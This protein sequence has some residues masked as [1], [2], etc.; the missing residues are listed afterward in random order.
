VAP[1]SH[2][3]GLPLS[4]SPAF[5]TFPPAGSPRRGPGLSASASLWLVVA[6]GMTF[7]MFG[8]GAGSSAASSSELAT[9]QPATT[10]AAEAPGED[11]AV[12]ASI[13][14]VPD[15]AARTGVFATVGG[16][17]LHLPAHD[18]IVTGFHQASTPGS[19]AMTPASGHR[20]LPSRGRGY[21]ATS[22]V[23]IVMMD[24]QPVRSPVSGTVVAVEGYSLYGRYPDSRIRIRPHDDRD[25]RV[26]MLHLGGVEVEVGD[27]VEAGV[28]ELAKRAR[29]FPFRS[30]VDAETKPDSWP[31]VHY[32]VKARG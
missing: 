16:L 19:Q 4:S 3:K 7:V 12:A 32:E 14:E 23:D 10:W 27:E 9:T 31:H 30:Q 17:A 15:Q 11:V 20:V 21:P 22:A 1:S 26:V 24:E 28:T 25:L 18:T 8:T 29:R 2:T 5:R 6:L 13:P